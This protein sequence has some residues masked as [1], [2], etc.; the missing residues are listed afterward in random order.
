VWTV[1]H[2]LLMLGRRAVLA[3]DTIPTAELTAN[4]YSRS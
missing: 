4:D 1:V 3:C 2:V